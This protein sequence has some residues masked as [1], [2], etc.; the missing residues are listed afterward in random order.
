MDKGPYTVEVNGQRC[1]AGGAR[2]AFPAS[3]CGRGADGGIPHCSS[4][5]GNDTYWGPQSGNW[6]SRGY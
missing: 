3:G 4:P 5:Q 6:D 2:D 1:A